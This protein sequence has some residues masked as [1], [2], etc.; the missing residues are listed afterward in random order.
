[1]TAQLDTRAPRRSPRSNLVGIAGSELSKIATNPV[2]AGGLLLMLLLPLILGAGSVGADSTFTWYQA[3]SRAALMGQ[4]GAVIFAAS[5]FGQEFEGSLLRTTY[6]AVPRRLMVLGVKLALCLAIVALSCL[7][8]SLTLLAARL[9]VGAPGMDAGAVSTSLGWFAQFTLTWVLMAMVG[10]GLSLILGSATVTIAIL[11]PLMLGLSQVFYVLT[12]LARFL[13]DLAG[14][15][16]INDEAFS[17]MLPPTI[18]AAVQAAWAFG[19]LA[20]GWK[21]LSRRDVH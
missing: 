3:L 17:V 4:L 9:A 5:V 15:R 1:M 8:W 19:L 2:C 13:P 6:I 7:A 12:D 16:L 14:Y 10:F 20:V 21:R 18:G 11:I